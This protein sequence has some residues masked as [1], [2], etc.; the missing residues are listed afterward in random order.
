MP[1]VLKVD[2]FAQMRR[3]LDGY[4]QVKDFLGKHVPTFSYPVTQEDLIGV[5]MELAAMEGSPQTLQ[6][7]FEVCTML[8]RCGV[9][10]KAWDIGNAHAACTEI[11]RPRL[12]YVDP[13]TGTPKQ[14]ISKH[15]TL[16]H[17]TP[18]SAANPTL[19]TERVI[20]LANYRRA[21]RL[22]KTT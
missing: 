18:Y 22:R 13:K 8:V 19:E 4:Y 21:T 14:G 5:G 16:F 11:V 7:S 12:N 1:R 3:E 20:E 6:D 17:I 9:E 10:S 15:S 2:N